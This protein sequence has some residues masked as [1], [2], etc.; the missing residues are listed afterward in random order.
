M[1]DEDGE[2]CMMRLNICRWLAVRAGVVAALAVSCCLVYADAVVPVTTA[3]ASH[4]GDNYGRG[5][6]ALTDGS[7]MD[8]SVDPV[9]PSTW[10]VDYDN[11][12][13]EWMGQFFPTSAV[14]DK[15]AWVCFDVG[16]PLLI[17]KLYLWNIRYGGGVAGTKSYN[18][19]YAS[20]P[21]VALPS[22]PSKG[23]WST[24][25]MTPQGDYDF[26]TGGWTLF[27]PGGPLSLGKA[28]DDVVV[29][30]GVTA[31]YLAIEILE[32]WG[33]T[34]GGGRVGFLEVALTSI[35]PPEGSVL[36]VR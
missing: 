30:G 2:D 10:T 11:Y 15:I 5:P 21:A 20:S 12:P 9:D 4:G 34:Y 35:P 33:D 31:R 17:D 23:S 32:N 1:R 3:P 14:N 28:V 6:I 7:G 27:N 29:I 13:D 24:T 8:R 18:L 22:Q 19:Y 16:E 36:V 26:S 25:G